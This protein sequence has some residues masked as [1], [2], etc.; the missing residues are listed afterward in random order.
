MNGY[1]GS[2]FGAAAGYEQANSDGAVG[3]AAA[4]MTNAVHDNVQVADASLSASVVEAGV[5]WRSTGPGLNASANVNAGLAFFQS[6]RYVIDQASDTTAATLIN[7]AKSNWNG[8]LV[9]AQIELNY[10]IQMGRFYL[11][12]EVSA[13]YTA[14]YESAHTESDGGSAVDLSIASKTNQEAAVQG[15][16]VMGA[17]FG[18]SVK[19]R[20]EMTIGWREIVA[21][22]PAST[23]AHFSAGGPSFVLSPQFTERGGLLARLGLRA[24]GAFADFS[25][26]A[27]G[28]FRSG[29]ETYDARAMA[30]FLF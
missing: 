25:A 16:M 8:G 17:T 29:Y 10:P 22:G 1:R 18:D 12:P 3:V 24:G 9:S 5:Y 30:R 14:L 4:F 7:S 2:G 15:D 19:W 23:T 27:G 20:P 6:H 28:V 21:G 13:D 26:D 11:R